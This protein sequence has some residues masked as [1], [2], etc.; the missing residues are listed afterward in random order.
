MAAELEKI[1]DELPEGVV[2]LLAIPFGLIGALLAFGIQGMEL[3]MLAMIGILGY[4]GVIVNDS[5]I[6]VD[7]INRKRL[8][9]KKKSLKVDIVEGA[10]IRLRPILLGLP[11]LA[12][13]N[14]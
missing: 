7:Y 2:R 9:E 1:I 5:L 10:V 13:V 11:G 6:L 3:S 14:F 4:S 12:W 8:R